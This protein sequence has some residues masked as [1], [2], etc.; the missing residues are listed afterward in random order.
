MAPRIDGLRTAFQN[1]SAAV[2]TDGDGYIGELDVVE[3]QG[4][5]GRRGARGG[6]TDEDWGILDG[7]IDDGFRA[8]RSR[9]RVEVEAN[10]II[11]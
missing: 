4:P 7:G 2:N 5:R 9:C 11:S 6:G 3:N 8:D 1:R 10:L